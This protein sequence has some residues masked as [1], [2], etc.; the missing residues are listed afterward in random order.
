MIAWIRTHW[1]FSATRIMGHVI[2]WL[3]LLYALLAELSAE[4]SVSFLLPPRYFAILGLVIFVLGLIVRKRGKTNA[5][6]ASL[7]PPDPSAAR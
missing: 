2:T 4:P 3:G 6:R 1:Y 5:E 7:P